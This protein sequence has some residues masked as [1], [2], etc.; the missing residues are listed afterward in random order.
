[1]ILCI[2]FLVC[3]LYPS[4]IPLFLLKAPCIFK[5]ETQLNEIDGINGA[6]MSLNALLVFFWKDTTDF[7]DCGLDSDVEKNRNNLDPR[8]NFGYIIIK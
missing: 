6:L 8:Q 3:D 1:M 7:C 5:M 4:L 2:G